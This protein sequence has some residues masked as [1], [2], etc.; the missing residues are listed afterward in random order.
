MPFVIPQFP[1]TASIWRVS[2][3]GGNYALPDV[4]SPANLSPGRRV[5]IGITTV[6]AAQHSAVSMEL[7]L[8]KLTDVRAAYNGLQPDIVEVPAGS[9]RFYGVVGVD[10]IG[11][12]FSNEHRIAWLSYVFAGNT[13]LAGGPFPAPVPLP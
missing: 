8:P 1:L 10:D 2:G 3:T 12:G 5:M 4:S 6:G 13:T 11:K 7:L 9:K